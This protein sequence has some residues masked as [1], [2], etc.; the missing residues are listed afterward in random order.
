VFIR[1]KVTDALDQH[2]E[3]DEFLAKA[4][5]HFAAAYPPDHYHRRQFDDYIAVRAV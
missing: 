4:A 3:A 2:L 1:A 5:E